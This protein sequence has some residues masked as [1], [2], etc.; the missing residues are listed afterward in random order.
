[1]SFHSERLVELRRRLGWSQAEMG[2][3]L[4]CNRAQVESWEM[5][6]EVVPAEVADQLLYL[7]HQLAGL[8]HAT[9]FQAVAENVM[10]QT[11]RTQVHRDEVDLATNQD[12]IA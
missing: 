8:A 6:Q 1:M 7:E 3:R 12:D 9:V 2:R 4:S 11:G 10:Q 5:A